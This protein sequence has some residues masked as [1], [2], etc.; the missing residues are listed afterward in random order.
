MPLFVEGAIWRREDSVKEIVIPDELKHLPEPWSLAEDGRRKKEMAALEENRQN[1]E[2]ALDALERCMVAT[3]KI[4]DVRDQSLPESWE[5]IWAYHMTELSRSLPSMEGLTLDFVIQNLKER[6]DPNSADFAYILGVRWLENVLY[7]TL[8]DLIKW[9]RYALQEVESDEADLRDRFLTL[10]E[11]HAH[12]FPDPFDLAVA[13]AAVAGVKAL[14]FLKRL[15]QDPASSDS[16]RRDLLPYIEMIESM[17]EEEEE[18]S[19]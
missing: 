11:N 18:E 17:M 2:A 16:L 19:T 14:P 7:K 6:N 3:K 1:L 8:D 13:A 15:Q 12:L 5:M 9:C 10:M 4:P